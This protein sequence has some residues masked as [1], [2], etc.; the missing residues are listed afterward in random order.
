MRLFQ[1]DF[2]DWRF[3]L[4]RERIEIPEAVVKTE[5][6]HQSPFQQPQGFTV[7]IPLAGLSVLQSSD[8]ENLP[9]SMG[10]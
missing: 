9:Q 6:N 1:K 3:S 4:G 8:P 2:S 5:I 7:E 10:P